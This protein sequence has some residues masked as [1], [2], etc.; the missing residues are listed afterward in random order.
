M[1]LSLCK[2]LNRYGVI[3]TSTKGKASK[4]TTEATEKATGWLALM[5]ADKNASWDLINSGWL[6]G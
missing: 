2:A 1:G 3:R 6:R 4:S 5:R